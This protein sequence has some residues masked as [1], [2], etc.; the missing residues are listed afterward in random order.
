LLRHYLRT[1][2]KVINVEFLLIEYY[3]MLRRIMPQQ[4]PIENAI[5]KRGKSGIFKLKSLKHVR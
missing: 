1:S 5:A 2:I 4:K 3:E